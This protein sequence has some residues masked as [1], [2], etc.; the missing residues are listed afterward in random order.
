[1]ATRSISLGILAFRIPSVLA[2]Y[3][4]TS[5]NVCGEGGQI[6][7]QILPVTDIAQIGLNDPPKMVHRSTERGK[8]YCQ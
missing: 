8:R 3:S 4:F 2:A 5:G 6:L 1:M 7:R